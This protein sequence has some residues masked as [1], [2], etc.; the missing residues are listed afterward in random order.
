MLGAVYLAQHRFREAIDVAA[1][2]R[3]ARPNDPVNYGVIGDGRLELGDYEE[4]FDAID[5]M[6]A[7]RPGA[8][9]Y[10]RVAYAR[11][12]QGDLTGA[13]QAMKLATDATSTQDVE[14]LA[15]THAQ[16]GEVYLQLGQARAAKQEF[17]IASRA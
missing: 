16:L 5:R 13:L 7:L 8:A 17:S 12:L 10:A 11:E 9:S 6:M 2:N 4:A 15:W 1:K 14:G 3:D